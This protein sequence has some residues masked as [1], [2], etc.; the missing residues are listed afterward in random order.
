MAGEVVRAEV[1]GLRDLQAEL[2]RLDSAWPRELR[3]LNKSVAELVVDEAESTGRSLGGVHAKTVDVGAFKARGEQRNATIVLDASRS[4]NAFA[5]GAEFGALQ[6]HQFPGWRGNRWT[7]AG[8]SGV[9]YMLHPAIR[10]KRDEMLDLYDEGLGRLLA[11]AF[12]D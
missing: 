7:D 5:F 10:D 3:L 9:G 11:R 2:R 1:R 6:Y 8:G 4:K 12:P